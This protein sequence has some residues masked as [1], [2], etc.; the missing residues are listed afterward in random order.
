MDFL[1]FKLMQFRANIK[2]DDKIITTN[3]NYSLKQCTCK[4]FLLQLRSRSDRLQQVEDYV[5]ACSINI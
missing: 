5:R 2:D 1:F 3:R 4:L